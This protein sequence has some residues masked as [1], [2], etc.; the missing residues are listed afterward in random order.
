MT[1]FPLLSPLLIA[2]TIAQTPAQIPAAPAP[3]KPAVVVQPQEIRPLPGQLDTVPTFNSNSPEVVQSEGIL[4]STFSP[5]GKSNPAAHLNYT[6]QGRF[7]LFAHHIAKAKAPDDLK[8]LHLGILVHNPGTQPITLTVLQAASYLSQPDAPFAKLPPLQDNPAGNIYAGPGDRATND[9]LRGLRQPNW[10]AT[11]VVSPGSTA[12]LFNAPIPVKTLTPPI[13]GRSTLARLRTTGPV[14]VASLATFAKAD[15]AGNERPPVLD[16]WQALLNN[17]NLAGPRDKVPTPPGARGKLIYGRVAGVAQGSRW[18]AQLSDP[19][20]DPETDPGPA[21]RQSRLTIPQAGKAFSYPLST[22]ERGTFGTG[23]VQSARMLARYPD[24]AYAAHGNY[25]IQYS[26]SLPL[27]NATTDCQNV[28]ILLQTP[29][30]SDEKVAALKFNSPPPE[31]VFFRGT[32]RVRY[33]DDAGSP[34]TRF[35]HLVHFQG[36]PG[37]PLVELNLQAQR[38]RFVQVDFLYPPDATPPQVLTV[39]TNQWLINEKDLKPLP[40]KTSLPM[41]PKPSAR[42]GCHF[43][44]S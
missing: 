4:L 42:Q 2:Q 14:Q 22:V 27:Y 36:Q 38:S 41:Q 25:G 21:P 32:V 40:N 33:Q 37:Q 31:K 26:L 8:T 34:V 9:V 19:G 5:A 17:G 7:D 15:A 3:P 35:I 28:A 10:P 6:F 43:T 18:Q 24:T 11:L 39:Q 1:M 13:N 12:L 20:A 16:E 30:K 29:L 23:Q 44:A